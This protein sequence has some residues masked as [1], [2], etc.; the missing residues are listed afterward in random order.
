MTYF[1]I[2]LSNTCRNYTTKT[3]S[4]DNRKKKI[5]LKIYRVYELEDADS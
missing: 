5:Q 4:I 2:N 1:K 3:K